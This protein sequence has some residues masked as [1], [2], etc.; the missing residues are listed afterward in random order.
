MVLPPLSRPCAHAVID[1]GGV[2]VGLSP[3]AVWRVNTLGAAGLNAAPGDRV[4][5]AAQAT[6]GGIAM[7]PRR[8]VIVVKKS[9]QPCPTHGA[10]GRRRRG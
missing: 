4:D 7:P 10:Q 3:V 6:E 1:S 2:D 5:D 8:E 9:A